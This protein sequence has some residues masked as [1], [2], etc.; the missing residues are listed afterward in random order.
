MQGRVLIVAGSDS[1][2]GAG[3][4]ADIKTV[5]ALRGYAAAAITAV[6][7]QNTK[8]V[9]GV[10]G[11][12]AEFVARQMEAVLSDIGADCIKTGMLHTAAIVDAVAEVIR[13]L[14]PRVPLVVDPVMIAKGGER[15]LKPA[16]IDALKRELLVRTTVLT[17]NIPEAESLTGLKVRD[18]DDLMHVTEMVQTLGPRAVLLTGGHMRGET[19]TDVLCEDGRLE[20]FESPRVSTPHTHG[21]GCTLA[22]AIATGIAQ[23]L[24]I[25]AAVV[26]AR[27]FVWQAILGAPGF[28]SGHGPIDHTHTVRPF[29][30]ED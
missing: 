27:A 9:S 22:S 1:G 21:T 5:T 18:V 3:V 11:V 24:G 28:G 20:V 7:A 25:R 15:L 6:T 13:R 17:P 23:G 10:H 14:A 26:R 16:A 8:G 30:G 4:Q 2:G 19:I 29:S 12:P